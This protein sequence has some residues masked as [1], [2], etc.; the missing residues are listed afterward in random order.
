LN[1]PHEV[2]DEP[3]PPHPD[4]PR[5]RALE[6]LQRLRRVAA[7]AE[8]AAARRLLAS[9]RAALEQLGLALTR[10]E[11]DTRQRRHAEAGEA[12]ARAATIATLKRRR[13]DEF[14][15]LA[16]IERHRAA[17]REQAD[18]VRQA[19]AQLDGAMQRRRQLEVRREK[20]AQ[21]IEQLSES[22]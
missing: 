1:A 15:M 16:A 7:D 20:F 8:L 9:A 22:P 12:A 18:T 11:Q 13:Q 19:E 17:L 5:L 4:L 14:N 2:A 21:L 3:A 10:R 6:Q